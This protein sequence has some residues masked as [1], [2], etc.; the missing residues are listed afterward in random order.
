MKKSVITFIIT[1][2]LFGCKSIEPI[3]QE[4]LKKDNVDN[5]EVKK[6]GAYYLDDG[7]DENPPKDLDKIPNASTKI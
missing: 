1:F 6:T 3:Y 2:L 7:P 5:A 4:E